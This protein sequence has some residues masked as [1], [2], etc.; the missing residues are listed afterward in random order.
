[1]YADGCGI[2][3]GLDF[4][5]V[6]EAPHDPLEILETLKYCEIVEQKRVAK[7]KLEDF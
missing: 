4:D 7:Y 1:M 6:W 2:G 3:P 5:R